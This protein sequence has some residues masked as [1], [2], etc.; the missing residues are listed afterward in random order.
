MFPDE[1]FLCVK[2]SQAYPERRVLGVDGPEV[3]V[4]ELLLRPVLVLH[5]VAQLLAA[6]VVSSTEKRVNVRK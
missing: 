6:V 3:V 1:G 4:E 5:Q 2:I